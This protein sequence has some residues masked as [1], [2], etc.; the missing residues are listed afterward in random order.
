MAI[1]N[2]PGVPALSIPSLP[3]VI[4]L[5][6]AD[7]ISLFAGVLNVPWGIYLG[8]IPV[9]FADNVTAFGYEQKFEISDYPVEGGDFESYNKVYQPF[10]TRL[11]FST[12]GNLVKRQAFLDSIAAIIGDLNLY[13]VVTENAVYQSVNLVDYTYRQTAG[14]GLGLIQVDVTARQ[15]KP[16]PSAALSNT[17]SP[18]NAGQVNLGPVQPQAATPAQTAQI[19]LIDGIPVT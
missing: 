15:V 13:N 7:A 6:T 16:A 4:S 8:V 17:V 18:T 1:P 11:R 14:S 12:G 5:L 3:S 19:L 9:V 2:V 10:E